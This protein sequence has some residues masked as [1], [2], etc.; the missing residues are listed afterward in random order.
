MITRRTFVSGLA[1]ATVA[2]AAPERPNIVLMMADDM[3]FSDIGCYG[4]EI[5]TP[6]LD[7]LAAGGMRFRQFYNCARC[8][9]TRASLMTGLYPHQ[10]G[11]GHMVN[12]RPYPA[13]AGDLSRKA[14]TIA[15]VLKAGGYR[16]WM[17]GK[18]HVTPVN[19]KK[20][21]WPLQRGFEKFFG[22]IHGAGSFYDPVT[23]AEGNEYVKPEGKDFYYTDAIADKAAGYIRSHGRSAEPFFLYTAFT[24]PHWPMHALEED[25]ERYKDR[26]KGGWDALREERHARMIEMGVV[27]RKWPLTPRDTAVPPWKD[28]PDKEWE[29]RRMAVYA[30]MIDR[31]DQGIGRIVEALRAA[32]KL[33]NTLI[34]FLADNGGCA[35]TFPV[36]VTNNNPSIPK[37]TRDGRPVRAGNDPSILPGRDD[38]YQS[39]GVGWA[40]ASNTPFRLYKHWVHEG[41]IS[42]PLI[43][44]WPR[45]VRNAG[46]WTSEPGHLID[47]MATAVDV[48][49]A[50]YP[51]QFEGNAVTPLE[52]KSLK[53]VF[54]SGKRKGHG[55]IY[56][57]HE[58]NRAVRQGK[59][60][61][62]LKHGGPWE[63]Y[64]IEAD[65]TEMNDLAAKFPVKVAELQTKWE[66]W[67]RKVGTVN[68][69]EV[70]RS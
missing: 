62:V 70:T 19:E 8:C 68:W 2:D 14:V 21:N 26:Y 28:A 46:S 65:R 10:A 1:A 24:A 29:A 38:D 23:L 35:E 36:R 32:G 25:I 27:D 64:D 4:G 56:W 63:L 40:N 59:W 61:L 48:S 5:R 51:K 49:G 18:W 42:T 41:G 22:T 54:E 34:L 9:P 60:K 43:A 47:V 66:A 3:G 16:T 69:D 39:Y 12:P 57:E 45:G 67:S 17:S 30:A 52:G 33:E 7:K 15:E 37:T 13:Y 55:E 31:M 11:V 53:P 50:K 6:N 20:H 58:G 44:H